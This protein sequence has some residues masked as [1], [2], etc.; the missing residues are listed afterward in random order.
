M[1]PCDRGAVLRER[2]DRADHVRQ[3]VVLLIAQ[4]VQ[5]DVR[6]AAPVR[7][8]GNRPA[9]WRPLRV[10]V[11]SVLLRQHVDPRCRDVHYCD[12]PRVEAERLEVGVASP[13]SGEGNALPV[14]G[15]LRLQLTV[16]VVRQTPALAGGDVDDV[17]V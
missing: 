9:V 1:R 3:L 10:E 7:Q 6:D 17:E 16:L 8:V 4:I 12:S 11:E 2:A 5:K 13:I 15:P 14:R